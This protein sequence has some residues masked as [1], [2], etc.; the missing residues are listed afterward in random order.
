MNNESD[1]Y[2]YMLERHKGRTVTAM[3]V[4]DFEKYM[5]SG[6]CSGGTLYLSDVPPGLARFQHEASVLGVELAPNTMEPDKMVIVRYDRNNE[7]KPYKR[8][9]Y[10]IQANPALSTAYPEVLKKLNISDSEQLRAELG[11]YIFFIGEY[12]GQDH[13]TSALATTLQRLYRDRQGQQSE[14]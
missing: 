14:R 11:N 4:Q 8:Y 13:H 7:P 3:K 10:E 9:N 5:N 2:I 6:I 12:K 1:K